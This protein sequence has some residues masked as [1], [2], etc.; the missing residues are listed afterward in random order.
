MSTQLRHTV[1]AREQWLTAKPPLLWNMQKVD[2]RTNNDC[3]GW[4][5]R[6]SNALGKH[7]P[8]IW[9]FLECLLEEQASVEVMHQQIRGG[10]LVRRNNTEFASI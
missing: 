5:V 6:F 8:S 4:H 3:E 9:K 7:H 1:L 2:I 10:R